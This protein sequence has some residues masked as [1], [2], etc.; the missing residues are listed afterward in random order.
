MN[1]QSGSMQA[2][3]H[4]SYRDDEIDLMELFTILWNGKRL[5]FGFALVAVLAG[6]VWLSLQKDIYSVSLK[7]QPLSAFEGR[8]LI[9]DSSEL[10]QLAAVSGRL[11]K[12]SG[13]QRSVLGGAIAVKIS[14]PG[15]KSTAYSVSIETPDPVGVPEKLNKLVKSASQEGALRLI[16]GKK[17]A[18]DREIEAFEDQLKSSFV[19]EA[20]ALAR[21]ELQKELVLMRVKRATMDKVGEISGVNVIKWAALPAKPIKPKRELVMALSVV[22]GGMIGVFAVFIRQG[23]RSYRAR[24]AG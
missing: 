23:L 7:F 4:S 9:I 2:N 18:I 1:Q 13:Y 15:R 17:Q 6:G 10:P 3:N 11:I 16:K 20:E 21:A 14:N 22:L 24:A 12:D 8:N 5:V 19:L